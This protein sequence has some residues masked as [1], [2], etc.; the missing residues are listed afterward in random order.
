MG[1]KINKIVFAVI[2]IWLLPC[3][4][5]YA[6]ADNGYRSV[7]QDEADLL[8][9][10]EE[11]NLLEA[12]EPITQYGNVAFLSTVDNHHSTGYYAEACYRDLFS[13]ESGTVFL[14]DMDNR[15][16]WIFSDGEIYDVVTEDYADTI[17]DN[18][19]RQASR[20]DYFDCAQNVYHQM[21]TIL[22]GG[23]I[24]QP[25][26]YMCN[27]LLAFLSSL[28]IF[29]F[30]VRFYALTHRPSD[31]EV[32]EMIYAQCQ[33]SNCTSTLVNQTKVY[34]PHTSSSGGSSGG[35]SSGGAR[36]SSGGGGGHR[37]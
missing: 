2:L 27:L 19:Y 7:I 15:N 20:A 14:I 30:V 11:K 21:D 28:L 8:T 22:S 37:F 32:K 34:H 4:L 6:K 5:L 13:H 33:I 16:I 23:R 24:A 35:R 10:A 29:Y 31:K 3:S 26:K 1:Y 18:V 9:D 17:T 36:R 25:M 12:M